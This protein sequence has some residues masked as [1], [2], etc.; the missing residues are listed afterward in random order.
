MTI[1]LP[2][3]IPEVL[4]STVRPD[5]ADLRDQLNLI[6]QTSEVWRDIIPASTG[7]ILI[8]FV[9]GVGAY[10]QYTIARYMQE[11]FFDTGKGPQNILTLARTLGVRIQ[12]KSPA[13]VGVRLTRDDTDGV[14]TVDRYTSF[15][16]DGQYFYNSEALA[17]ADGQAQ[18]DTTLTEGQPVEHD[19]TSNGAAWQTYYVGGAFSSSDTLCRVLVDGVEWAR[20]RG[21]TWNADP[22][23]DGSEA[24]QFADNTSASGRAEIQFGNNNVGAIPPAAVQV[25]IIEY[26]VRGAAA[27]T[28]VSGIAGSM[29]SDTDIGVVTT[30]AVYGADDEPAA[31]I[32]TKTGAAIGRSLGRYVSRSDYESNLLVYPGVVDV[33]VV[34]EHETG[35]ALNM[36]NVVNIYVLL[37]A[38][39]ATVAA[40]EAFLDYIYERGMLGVVHRVLFATAIPISVTGTVLVNPQYSMSE[41]YAN[42]VAAVGLLLEPKDGSIGAAVFR[43]DIYHAIMTVPGVVHCVLTL[44]TTD[45]VPEYN[46][47]VQLSDVALSAN[48]YDR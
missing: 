16:V 46:E 3:T 31:A 25:K 37:A 14:Y 40:Q 11:C 18:L 6:L 35:T 2:D 39:F 36:M 10:D 21:G 34:G 4:L 41:V 15:V 23:Y 33:K 13:S 42:A 26:V 47:W 19:F 38:P 7:E 8:K 48:Y 30:T 22:L 28:A 1:Q 9:A 20:V 17:F 24:H 43:S 45:T 12:R 5:Y 29:P 44:P 27:N 32:Y